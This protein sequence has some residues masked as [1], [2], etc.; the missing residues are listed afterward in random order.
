MSGKKY[1]VWKIG[2]E[3][4][5]KEYLYAKTHREASAKYRSTHEDVSVHEVETMKV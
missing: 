1:A 2:N 3:D 5:T 4:E